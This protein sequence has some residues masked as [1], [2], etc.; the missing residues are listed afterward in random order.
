MLGLT[1]GTA[2]AMAFRRLPPIKFIF[3]VAHF[4]LALAVA[5]ICLRLVAGEHAVFGARLW[6]G[7]YLGTQVGGVMTILLLAAALSL[8]DGLISRQA[9]EGL[10]ERAREA[11]R[12]DKAEVV[13]FAAEGNPPLRTCLGPGDRP[14]TL[15][16]VD[17]SAAAALG[18]ARPGRARSA[19]ARCDR[20]A[21]RRQRDTQ[22]HGRHPPGR[23]AD[24]RHDHAR[25]PHR[26]LARFRRG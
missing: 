7:A 11:F 10:L 8:A 1:L 6:A 21:G 20:R 16:P 4:T 23:A 15:E 13:L 19:A 2:V 9:I 3:N 18:R 26:A 5:M 12:A 25:Q 14:E 17:V 24:D 22:C